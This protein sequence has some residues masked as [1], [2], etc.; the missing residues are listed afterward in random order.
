MVSQVWFI[1]QFKNFKLLLSGYSEIVKNQLSALNLQLDVKL[2]QFDLTV[3]TKR[4][5]KLAISQEVK[6]IYFVLIIPY[7]SFTMNVIILINFLENIKCVSLAFNDVVTQISN[8][9]T[10]ET[11]YLP[12]N[13]TFQSCT[14]YYINPFKPRRTLVNLNQDLPTLDSTSE[15]DFR[16]PFFI[17]TTRRLYNE[18]QAMQERFLL[19]RTARLDAWMGGVILS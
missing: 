14:N 4:D 11:A 1:F 3:C 7:S 6:I 16:N 12:P 18:G 19:V 10:G 15:L 8:L 5:N 17:C 13:P 9:S 2:K